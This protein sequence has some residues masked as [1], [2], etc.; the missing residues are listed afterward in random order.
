MECASSYSSTVTHPPCRVT[1]AISDHANVRVRFAVG[2]G[3]RSII[4]EN[5]PESDGLSL[6]DPWDGMMK[7]HS[8]LL[9]MLFD[10]IVS[11]ELSLDNLEC[12]DLEHWRDVN[13]VIIGTFT[14]GPLV[15]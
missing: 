1:F 9:S 3:K 8:Q 12:R 13:A 15:R 4:S 5:P 2:T 11:K 10:L 7:A 6:A 14:R